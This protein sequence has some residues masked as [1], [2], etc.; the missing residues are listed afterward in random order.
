MDD[1]QERRGRPP[2]LGKG[3]VLAHCSAPAL[4]AESDESQQLAGRHL[5]CGRVAAAPTGSDGARFHISGVKHQRQ[6]IPPRR[7]RNPQL[8][9]PGATTARAASV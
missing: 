8:T 3:A 2:L 7:A 1:D 4:A 5:F 9:A 6:P